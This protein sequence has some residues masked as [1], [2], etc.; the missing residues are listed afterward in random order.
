VKSSLILPC[1]LLAIVATAADPAPKAIVTTS[2]AEAGP[3]YQI[4]GEYA[5]SLDGR[6]TG[7]QVIALGN[8]AF[9]AVLFDGGLPGAGGIAASR[10]EVD[11]A[12]AD[13]TTVFK[14]DSLSVTLK[15]G[16]A[17][18]A[19]SGANARQGTLIRTER[20]SPTLGEKA[21]SG[22]VILFDGTSAAQFQGGR[23]TDDGLL[24][25]GTTSIKKFGS[26]RLHIEF[27]TPF[28][29]SARGQGRGNSGVYYQ[30]RYE[31]Q[32]LDSFGLLGK[33]NE[34]GGVYSIKDPAV[35]M[36]LPPLV[37][38]T[39][40][41]EFTAAK[42]DA[43]GKKIKN[44]RLTTRLNGVVVQDDTELPNGTTAAP[45]KEGPEPGP[46]YL[47]NHGNPVRFRNIWLVETP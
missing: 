30:G 37:W 20:K 47:Q 26:H 12:T 39:Y 42:Y 28:M 35:N 2:V 36:C 46:L 43:E 14:N 13:G 17:T 5:G 44:A 21:P 31:T 45:V 1:A 8:G 24:M 9:K 32:V 11:G 25:E 4:Q 15:D 7:L 23:M 41:T 6:A 40:D 33:N 27:M 34:T 3:D 16:K 38:Q 18:T 10:V 19:I 22:A 29:P